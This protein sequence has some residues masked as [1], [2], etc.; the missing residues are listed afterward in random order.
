ML[1]C[2]MCLQLLAKN[3]AQYSLKQ[4]FNKEHF[5]SNAQSM[6]YTS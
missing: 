1:L 2:F 5:L 4:I 3:K 6:F